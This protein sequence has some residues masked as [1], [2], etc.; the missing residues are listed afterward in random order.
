MSM[1]GYIPTDEDITVMV[2]DL[3]KKGSYKR[4]L[5]ICERD[6]YSDEVDVP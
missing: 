2:R 6:A 4:E 1:T 5:G 3:E